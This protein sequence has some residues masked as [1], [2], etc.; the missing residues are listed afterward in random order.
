MTKQNKNK[1]ARTTWCV[2]CTWAFWSA[3]EHSFFSILGRKIF[4]GPREKTLRTPP[5]IFSS[6]PD[7]TPSKKLFLFILF[8]FFFFFNFYLFI[9]S[10]KFTLPNT[11]LENLLVYSYSKKFI[12]HAKGIDVVARVSEDWLI[13]GLVIRFYKVQGMPNVHP[14][15]RIE[16][17]GFWIFRRMVT[18]SFV[19]AGELNNLILCFSK[20]EKKKK[21]LVL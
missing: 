9:S 11:I 6:S 2:L 18:L 4:N 8:F 12:V 15:I 21:N 14:W 1:K 16:T 5:H 10:L 19:I 17:F 20:K 3:H 7:Q 13:K